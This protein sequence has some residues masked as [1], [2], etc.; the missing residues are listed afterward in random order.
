MST[1]LYDAKLDHVPVLAIC[2][3]PKSPSAAPVISKNLIWIGCMRTFAGFV[4]DALAPAQV[5]HQSTA[6]RQE[7]GP[8]SLSDEIH[9]FSRPSLCPDSQHFTPYVPALVPKGLMPT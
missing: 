9:W 4:Q 8:G 3:R 2:G 1:G 6:H 7:F 5:R